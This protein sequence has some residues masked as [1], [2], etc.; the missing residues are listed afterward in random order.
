VAAI[1]GDVG[2]VVNCLLDDERWAIR[3]LVVPTAAVGFVDDFI[4][5]DDTW[6]TRSV[7][8]T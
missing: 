7:L 6:E 5:D 2:S 1:D 4:I 8:A 3:H